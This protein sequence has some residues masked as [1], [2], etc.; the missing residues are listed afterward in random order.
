MVRPGFPR[1][2]CE[3]VCVPLPG[4]EGTLIRF[5]DRGLIRSPFAVSDRLRLAPERSGRARMPEWREGFPMAIGNTTP[6]RGGRTGSRS[7]D[8]SRPSGSEL[9]DPSTIVTIFPS[10]AR[11]SGGVRCQQ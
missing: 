2:S 10:R 1:P 6:H 5:L 8:S 7:P 9:P 11:A 3:Q 4:C